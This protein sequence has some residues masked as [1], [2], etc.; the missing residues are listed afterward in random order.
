MFTTRLFI[1]KIKSFS[2]TASGKL[3]YMYEKVISF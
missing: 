2:N 3:L 1:L